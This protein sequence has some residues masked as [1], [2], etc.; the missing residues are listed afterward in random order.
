MNDY[1]LKMLDAQE[2]NM[3]RIHLDFYDSI[4][5]QVSSSVVLDNVNPDLS[6]SEFIDPEDAALGDMGQ[7]DLDVSTPANAAEEEEEAADE[8][9]EEEEEEGDIDEELAAE[10]AR[11]MGEEAEDDDDEEGS[12]SES[13]EDEDED[14]DE[15]EE[16]V[17]ARK[18]LTEE[19]GDLEVAISR[20]ENEI[21][22]SLNPLIKVS[23][24]Y[25]LF[26]V[27]LKTSRYRNVLKI[28]FERCGQIWSRNEPNVSNWWRSNV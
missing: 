21:N 23:F 8:E 2:L 25:H 5:Q 24:V 26:P 16:A 15:D 12:E 14:E 6:D 13:E 22:A 28:S 9:E 1:S 27:I 4:V 19:I 18:L 20:K 10:L 7:D 11:E 3:V 17:Q